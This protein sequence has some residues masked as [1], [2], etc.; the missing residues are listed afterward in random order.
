MLERV[1]FEWNAVPE[2]WI[3]RYEELKDYMQAHGDCLVP[4]QYSLNPSL[5]VWVNHQRTQY[6]LFRDG[7]NSYLTTERIR[8]LERLNFEWSAV[9]AKWMARFVEL[10][11]HVREHGIGTLPAKGDNRGLWQWVKYQRKLYRNKYGGKKKPSDYQEEDSSASK[12]QTHNH[13]TPA[14]GLTLEREQLLDL[15]G[16]PW[17]EEE[18]LPRTKPQ[19]SSSTSSSKADD[20]QARDDDEDDISM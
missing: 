8:M 7:K 3:A 9:N 19:R 1:G 15:L 2:D 20:S 14:H 6:K 18:A 17:I 16:F 12:Q 11:K 4:Q 5:G 13:D 10:G